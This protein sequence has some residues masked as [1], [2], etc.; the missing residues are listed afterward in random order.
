MTRAIEGVRH[1]K[2]YA[3]EFMSAFGDHPDVHWLIPPEDESGGLWTDDPHDRAEYHERVLQ[4][5][6]ERTDCDDAT[7]R[8]TAYVNGVLQ[9]YADSV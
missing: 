5:V 4:Y 2:K 8:R 1:D 3:I 9:K 6:R 7:W